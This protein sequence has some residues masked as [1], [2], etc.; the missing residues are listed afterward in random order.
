M[1]AYVLVDCLPEEAVSIIEEL[2]RQ[3]GIIM[4]DRVN[5]PHP[6]ICVVEGEDPA[7]LADRILFRIRKLSG[8]KDIT[9]Y[10]T[11]SID[12]FDEAI[13]GRHPEKTHV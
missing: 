9:V 13:S 1:R 3:P 8:I 2:R 6:I 10:L 12:T 7:N 5:G 11:E 4:A